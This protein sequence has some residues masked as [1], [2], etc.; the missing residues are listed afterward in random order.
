V[1]SVG[2]KSLGTGFLPG[3]F[4]QRQ[5]EERPD[6]LCYTT[7]PLSHDLEV[8]GPLSVTLYAASSAPDTDWTAKLVDVHP[9][10]YARNLQE[11]II[12]ASYR[13]GA[14]AA[15]SPIRPGEVEEYTIDL[16]ATSNVFRAG[17]CIRVEI[18]SSNFPHWDRNPNTGE[19][20]ATATRLQ[21]A[22]Q[23]VFHDAAHPSHIVLPLV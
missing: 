18:A 15:P 14:A 22:Q 21:T 8:T 12:R 9:D 6:V 4:D 19:P 17:H 3:V 13:L 5:V 20:A 7:P 16:W 10:G 23:R 1:P 11:G 2:G